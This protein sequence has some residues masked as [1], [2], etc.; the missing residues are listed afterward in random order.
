MA[1]FRYAYSTSAYHG[2]DVALSIERLAS[3]GYE[4]IELGGEPDGYDAPRVKQLAAEAGIAVASVCPRYTAERDLCNPDAAVRR[5][6]V[7]Y[8]RAAADLAAETG[9]GLLVVCP[10]AGMKTARLA[11]P[12]EEWRWAIESIREA[13]EYAATV[14]VDVA[15]EPWNRYET[16]FLN[17]VDQAVELWHELGL[18]NGGVMGDTFHM[19]IE[20]ASVPDAFRAAKGLLAHAHLADSNRA[21]PGRGHTDFRPILRAL[22][23]VDYHGY[24]AV[25][26]FPPS[27][28]GPDSYDADTKQAL[29]HLKAVEREL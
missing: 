28:G 12:A 2:E 5:T 10:S 14:G 22:L 20:E 7:D 25:E 9:A 3:C 24:L 27:G 8:V 6:A 13:G 23:D 21:V 15:L 17:R 4:A 18:K 1:R 11:P 19:N 16:Y 29:D 26:L